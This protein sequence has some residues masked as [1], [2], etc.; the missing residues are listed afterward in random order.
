MF[1][2]ILEG[3]PSILKKHNGVNAKI[4]D[5]IYAQLQSTNCLEMV[6]FLQKLIKMKMSQRLWSVIC[7]ALQFGA[8]ILNCSKA[9]LCAVIVQNDAAY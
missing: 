5:L 6:P 4:C 8:D 3:I 1:F 9:N 2:G 7:K